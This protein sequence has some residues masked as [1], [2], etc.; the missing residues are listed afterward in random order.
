[1][2]LGMKLHVSLGIRP[3]YE[4]GNQATLRVWESGHTTSLGIRPHYEAVCLQYSP[5]A[6][7]HTHT[8]QYWLEHM[9]GF[10]RLLVQRVGLAPGHQVESLCLLLVNE[11]L[12]FTTLE[13]RG[14]GRGGEGRGGE[15]REDACSK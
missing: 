5:Y 14:E 1:M 8:H 7:T 13:R 12:L 11:L 3:Y 9:L 2:S 10:S 15:G 6:H 4:S